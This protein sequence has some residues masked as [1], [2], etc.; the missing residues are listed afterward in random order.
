MWLGQLTTFSLFFSLFTL[1]FSLLCM[2]FF[3]Y[4]YCSIPYNCWGLRNNGWGKRC[5]WWRSNK[6]HSRILNIRLL[7]KMRNTNFVPSIFCHLK[8]LNLCLTIMTFH[9][10]YRRRWMLS[11]RPWSIC[12]WCPRRRKRLLV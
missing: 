2:L 5:W 6:R 9:I 8:H 12:W 3:V 4:H 7:S 11:R 1:F 10:S